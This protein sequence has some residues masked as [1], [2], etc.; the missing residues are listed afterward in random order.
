MSETDLHQDKIVI[1]EAVSLSLAPASL[2]RRIF[3]AI[4]DALVLLTI[5]F[6]LLMPSIELL[7]RANADLISLKIVGRIFLISA[8]LIIPALVETFT[9]GRSL[10]K[11][12]FSL[13]VIRDDGGVIGPRHAFVRAFLWI[14]EGWL[15][16]GSIAVLSSML[17][18]RGKR[19]GDIAAGTYVVYLPALKRAKLNELSPEIEQ[20][21]IT[22]SYRPLPPSLVEQGYQFLAFEN[23]LT[24]GNSNEQAIRLANAMLTYF[25]PSPPALPPVEMVKALLATN[26][27]NQEEAKKRSSAQMDKVLDKVTSLSYSND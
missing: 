15:S 18:T 23:K 27:K 8:F 9:K 26:A 21:R 16:I 2:V 17:V 3:S 7:V 1:G 13:Q 11:Y 22:S 6:V 19:L 14:I 10:G 24:T 12:L 5:V 20:W 4:F 25:S